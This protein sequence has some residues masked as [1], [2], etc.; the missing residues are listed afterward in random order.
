M[1]ILNGKLTI[2]LE[3]AQRDNIHVTIYCDYGI[4]TKGKVFMVDNCLVTL[5]GPQGE[6]VYVVMDKI[7]TITA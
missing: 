4:K 1:S 7:I 5:I 2:L 6:Y 3:N